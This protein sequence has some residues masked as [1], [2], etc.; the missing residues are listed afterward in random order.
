MYH[1][2]IGISGSVDKEETQSFIMRSYF[3]RLTESG[4]IPLLLSPDMTPEQVEQCAQ[5]LDG[6]LLAGGNDVDPALFHEEPIPQLGEVNPIRDRIELLLVPAFLRAEKP[7]LGI[8]R[9]IQTLNVALG[10]TLYQ[11]LPSQYAPCAPENHSQEPPYSNPTHS[12]NVISG[13]AFAGIAQ[14]DELQVNSMHHQAVKDVAPGLTVCATSP[15]GVTEAV[16]M[17]GKPFV[18][19][20]QWHPERLTDPASLRLFERFV[21][22]AREKHC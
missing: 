15:T 5:Q 12:V 18:I 21:S 9:G 17:P 3:K 7:I 20:V 8:C 1:P 19:G 16:E 14:A 6:L 2:L 10:G 11:D 13:T 22:A 4:A